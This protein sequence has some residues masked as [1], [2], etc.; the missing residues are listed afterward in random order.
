MFHGKIQASSRC[1]VKH[2][3]AEWQDVRPRCPTR[4][5]AHIELVAISMSPAE[6]EAELT[7]LLKAYGTKVTREFREGTGITLTDRNGNKSRS[8]YAELVAELHLTGSCELHRLRWRDTDP[9]GTI[10]AWV[11]E[12]LPMVI[13]T[14]VR[15]SETL[16][17]PG[18][19]T[20]D[21]V[22]EILDDVIHDR[23]QVAELS[24]D[25]KTMTAAFRAYRGYLTACITA[26][27]AFLNRLPWFARN[28]PSTSLLAADAKL[29][30]KRSSP[31][32]E[33]L[34]RWVP[35]LSGGKALSE[36]G[37]AWTSCQAIRTARNA[38]VHV[39]EPDFAFALRQAAD[40]LNLCRPGVGELL[41]DIGN[42]L[43]RNPAPAVLRV[44]RSPR[45][46]Y[47]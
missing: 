39:N 23:A 33:K 19:L 31:L 20:S 25:S 43:G 28:E 45:A 16:L 26:V 34:R 9:Y 22:G 1:R 10:S 7:A 3:A 46:N 6:A 27:D 5:V 4:F 40:A 2:R 17:G 37:T 36:A 42:L 38:Y 29:L 41:V 21:V 13:G 12:G 30:S 11:P 47:V 18:Y 35:V 24:Q 15:T 8:T 32:E 44:A 14:G